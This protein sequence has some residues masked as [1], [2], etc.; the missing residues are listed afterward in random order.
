LINSQVSVPS[1][2]PQGQPTIYPS[3]LSDS[4]IG[5]L[6]TLLPKVLDSLTT[7]RN[8]ELPARV[9]IRTAPQA[10]LAALP[11]LEDSVQAIL[12][13]RPSLSSTEPVDPIYQTPAWLIT[14]ANLPVKTV[15]SLDRY[16]TSRSQV[17]RVQ[18]VGYFD[19]GGPTARV[20]AVIDTNNGRPRIVYY[21]D[22]TELGK[23]FDLSGSEN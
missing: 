9:N 11:G 16:I 13:N 17:Y 6:R 21:R 12:A 20:E 7:V 8:G 3:P 10:V 1:D 15:S 18:V 5:K 2:D 23:G 4:D 19:G 14:E 22:L